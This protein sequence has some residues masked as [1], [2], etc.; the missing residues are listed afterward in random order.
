MTRGRRVLTVLRERISRYL[1]EHKP[2]LEPIGGLVEGTINRAAVWMRLLAMVQVAFPNLRGHP[3]EKRGLLANRIE[4]H[5]KSLAEI[6]VD[7][8][9]LDGLEMLGVPR[10]TAHNW[11]K[12]AR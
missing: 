6:D 1:G 5:L 12:G 10:P 7:D 3:Q 9:I 2:L 8:V 4:E 11:L